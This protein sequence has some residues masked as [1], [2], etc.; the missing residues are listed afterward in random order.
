MLRSNTLSPKTKTRRRS[1]EL[2]N[3]WSAAASALGWRRYWAL[4]LLLLVADSPSLGLQIADLTEIKPDGPSPKGVCFRLAAVL[5]VSGTEAA[6]KGVEAAP[7]LAERT[8]TRRRRVGEAV[9]G[10]DWS[11]DL[12]L[13]KLVKVSEEFEDVSAAAAGEGERWPVVLE[14]LAEGV[15]VPTLLVLVSTGSTGSWRG[16]ATCGGGGWNI[17]VVGVD[18]CAFGV[19]ALHFWAWIH[20]KWC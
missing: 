8:R 1:M 7:G 9:E 6:D 13:A 19:E 10:A 14:V 4:P 2:L 12:G 16:R 20:R 11:M 17:V 3:S 15:P 5:F 18:A